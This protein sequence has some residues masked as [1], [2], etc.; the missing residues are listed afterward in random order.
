[1][2]STSSYWFADRVVVALAAVFVALALA[3]AN[4]RRARARVI[5]V[6]TLVRDGRDVTA[7]VDPPVAPSSPPTATV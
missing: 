6:R 7:T 3:C 4:W 5:L 2:A 1:M